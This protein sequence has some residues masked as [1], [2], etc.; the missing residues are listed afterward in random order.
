MLN[1]LSL[2]NKVYPR[3]VISDNGIKD[4]LPAIQSPVYAVR[5]QAPYMEVPDTFFFE[6]LDTAL[7]SVRERF[8]VYPHLEFKVERFIRFNDDESVE[9]N[10]DIFYEF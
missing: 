1:Q 9:F 7:E 10:T 2:L 4:S 8:E 3:S 5:V 6:S